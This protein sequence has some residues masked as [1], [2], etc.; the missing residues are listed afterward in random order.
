MD[1]KKLERLENIRNFLENDNI[2][3]LIRYVDK[4]KPLLKKD[5]DFEEVFEE[6]QNKNWDQALLVTEDIIFDMKGQSKN[7]DYDEA[8]E[9]DGDEDDFIYDNKDDDFGDL[10][11][12]SF[13]D[14]DFYDDKDDD[15]F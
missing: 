12:D 7:D 1:I 15:Y 11:L 6:I 9:F 2:P 5:E 13:D 14:G 10:G 8:E 4:I 3:A